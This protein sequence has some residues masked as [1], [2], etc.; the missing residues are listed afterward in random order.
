MLTLGRVLQNLG[1]TFLTVRAGELRPARQVTGVV[2]HD[3]VDPLPAAEGQIVLAPGLGDA[4]GTVA[5]LRA[6]GERD[7]CAVVVREPVDVT[8]ELA[9]AAGETGVLLLSLVRGASWLQVA[10]L[11]RPTAGAD[12]A[13]G[14]HLAG[15]ADAHLDLFE[16]ANSLSDLLGAPITIEDLSSRILAFSADQDEADDARKASVL[17]QQV[18]RQY[19][20][21]LVGRGA[22]RRLYGSDRPIFIDSIGP[23]VR[24]RV[25]MRIRAGSE[26]LGSIWAV[27]DALPGERQQQ[28]MI[29][30]ANIAAIVML[31]SRVA[32]DASLRIRTAI[33]TGLLEGGTAAREAAAQ[34]GERITGGCVIAAGLHADDAATGAA[35]SADLDRVS[36]ALSMLLRS[37][38]PAAVVAAVGDTI[39]AVVPGR[40]GVEPDVEHL[41]RLAVAFVRRQ[42]SGDELAVAVG[43]VVTDA[44]QLDRS[45][46]EAD[47][48]LRVL[49]AGTGGPHRQ[50]ACARDV[51]V[52][53]LLMQ[54]SDLMA[55]QDVKL[56][57][58]LDRLREYD[59]RH[60]ATLEPT[61]RAWLDSFGD[62]AMAAAALHVHKNTLRYRLARIVEIAGVDLSDPE[63]R[64]AL[65]LQFRLAT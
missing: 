31:R 34:L 14:R 18:P 41:R 12:N 7:G 63:A 51:Q 45:R 44:T 40:D 64:F 20:D 36:R 61:L 8:P 22:F 50:V 33:V 62:V 52:Q 55:G 19:N 9:D 26:V 30:A 39:Y 24:P 2:F 65:M 59:L 3:A 43:P 48:T 47:L 6:V 13:L 27:L 54:L 1:P 10:D 56:S 17:G 15:E 58:P 60:D 21:E 37:E 49:R 5:L 28:A 29:E 42:G 46:R 57:G 35:L 25:A 4:T 32:A 23:G 53:C 11:L 38:V 16:V